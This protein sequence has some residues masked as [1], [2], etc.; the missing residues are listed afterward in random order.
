MV[1]GVTVESRMRHHGRWCAA[2]LLLVARAR[3]H[4]DVAPGVPVDDDGAPRR[5]RAAIYREGV[6]EGI[7]RGVV[8]L[9]REAEGRGN[10]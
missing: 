4:A 6:E 1:V 2:V 10:G 9:T 7:G 8:D 3:R 5:A